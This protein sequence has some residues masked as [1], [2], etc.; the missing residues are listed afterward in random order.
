MWL[1]G[2]G[3]STAAGPTANHF[4]KNLKNGTASPTAINST[5]ILKH[6]S[7]VM[8][9]YNVHWS[10]EIP[11]GIPHRE[12]LALLLKAAWADA[13]TRIAPEALQGRVGIL[14]ASTKGFAEDIAWEHD[15]DQ[16]SATN[17]IDTISP[18]LSDFITH[19]GLAPVQKTV[20]TGACASVAVAVGVA[21]QWFQLDHADSILIIAC[22]SIGEFVLRG[23]HSL[24]AL[25]QDTHAKPFDN[26]RSGLQLG[27]AAAVL[28][29]SNTK[30]KNNKPAVQISAAINC[31]G[32]AA[33]RPDNNGRSLFLALEEVLKNKVQPRLVIAH[34]TG[35]VI[36]DS[37]EDFVLSSLYSNKKPVVTATKWCVGHTLGVSC[38]LD[39]IA[40]H[41]CLEEKT[42][43]ALPF[44]T[45]LPQNFYCE[46]ATRAHT[47]S[48]LG[49][50]VLVSSL[51][52]GGVHAGVLL[53][54][55]AP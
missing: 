23:F 17:N 26:K 40:A 15:F 55:I 42:V 45:S 47:P 9:N 8:P 16:N 14:L 12:R 24:Q 3:A 49:S 11:L 6:R 46:Y 30:P 5:S 1:L 27:E 44:T 37:T 13:Q 10:Q 4:W 43:F 39:I 25:T 54:E 28:C 19:S 20:V 7:A 52:F 41:K 53:E 36:N 21:E 50:S 32:V 2:Y 29:L 31:E 22:D 35:T 38:A 33:T 18:V 48:W 34:G 51:G